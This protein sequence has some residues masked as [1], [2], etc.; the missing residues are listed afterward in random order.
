MGRYIGLLVFLSFLLFGFEVESSFKYGE[1]IDPKYTCRGANISLPLIF[2]NIPKDTKSIAVLMEDPD[3]PIGT[4][5]HW[6]IYNIPTN[7]AYLKENLP[8]RYILDGG[9][10]QGVN[11]FNRVGYDGP[12]PPN[13]VHRY[14]IKAFALKKKLPV[15]KGIRK[16]QFLKLIEGNVIAKSELM[17]RF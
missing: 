15:I 17:G 13:G 8:K 5:V 12:C 4:F 2:N 9:I 6:I 16:D 3:A 7:R 10:V 11:D 14:Y 1:R